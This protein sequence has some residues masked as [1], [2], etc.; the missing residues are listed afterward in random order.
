MAI[1]TVA[2][3]CFCKSVANLYCTFAYDLLVFWG[4][5]SLFIYILYDLHR[6]NVN[7]NNMVLKNFTVFL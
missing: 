1:H 7:D 5:A 2:I 6:T 4:E 3:L